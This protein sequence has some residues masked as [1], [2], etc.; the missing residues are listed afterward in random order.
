MQSNMVVKTGDI[1]TENQYSI[2]GLIKVLINLHYLSSGDRKAP[3]QKN[4]RYSGRFG[5]LKS[6]STPHFFRNACTK[7]GSL[8]FSQFPV[9]D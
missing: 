7:S 5:A 6:Y 2:I 4:L 1:L 8:R 3:V 9:V